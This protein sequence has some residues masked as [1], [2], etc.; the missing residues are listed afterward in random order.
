MKKIFVSIILIL[1]LLMGHAFAQ[2][3][4]VMISDKP[5][6]HKIGQITASFKMEKEEL[7]VLGADKFKSI[8]VKA[9]D[10]PIHIT[11][12]EIYFESGEMES[13]TFGTDLN[14]G[15][16]SKEYS[17]KDIEKELKKVVLY[18]GTIANQKNDK[19]TVEIYGL[20]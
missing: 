13:I 1:P 10:A 5:G 17:L 18:Y 4:A 11:F 8:K 19:S 20:K 2:K 15:Q 7:V 12:I 9:T 16:E 14:A 6:W 3:P